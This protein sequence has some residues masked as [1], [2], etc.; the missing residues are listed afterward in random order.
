MGGEV[1]G[2]SDADLGGAREETRYAKDEPVGD[3]WCSRGTCKN[4]RGGSTSSARGPE[5]Q[6]WTADFFP[7]RVTRLGLIALYVGWGNGDESY[8][9]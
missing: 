1:S 7:P 6:D 5:G 3:A 8:E 9:N 2:D 4:A